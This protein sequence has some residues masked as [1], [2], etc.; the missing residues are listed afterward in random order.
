[1]T[2]FNSFNGKEIR[3]VV[4]RVTWVIDILDVKMHTFV[5]YINLHSG[6]FEQLFHFYAVLYYKYCPYGFKLPKSEWILKVDYVIS[7]EL[8]KF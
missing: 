4:N 3:S 2:V 1:M 7:I 6:L 8:Q 5:M